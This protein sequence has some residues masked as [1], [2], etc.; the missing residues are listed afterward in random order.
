MMN[1]NKPALQAKSA[2]LVRCF[3]AAVHNA[4]DINTVPC[5]YG[6]YNCTGL[7]KHIMVSTTGWA[8]PKES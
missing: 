3:D 2:D 5:D 1:T 6:T 4:S 8:G 7:L